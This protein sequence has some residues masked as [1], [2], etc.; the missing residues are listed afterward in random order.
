MPGTISTVASA[1][2]G[3]DGSAIEI[4]AAGVVAS[5]TATASSTS[6]STTSSIRNIRV[7]IS[8]VSSSNS[9]SASAADDV[10]DAIVVAPPVAGSR[11]TTWRVARSGRSTSSAR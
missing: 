11:R 3:I 8:T 5:Q 1:E 6:R 2:D 10:A 7:S 9:S 4:G